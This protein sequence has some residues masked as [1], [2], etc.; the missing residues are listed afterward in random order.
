MRCDHESGA[1]CKPL[2]EAQTQDD[3]R[4]QDVGPQAGDTSYLLSLKEQELQRSAEDHAAS[5]SAVVSQS[6]IHCSASEPLSHIPEEHQEVLDQAFGA[7]QRPAPG[8]AAFERA[9]CAAKRPMH[10]ATCESRAL[11]QRV[12]WEEASETR[13]TSWGDFRRLP[14]RFWALLHGRSAWRTAG[15]DRDQDPEEE[16]E[17]TSEA[18]HEDLEDEE[19]RLQTEAFERAGLEEVEAEAMRRSGGKRQYQA[20]GDDAVLGRLAEGGKRPCLRD[21]TGLAAQLGGC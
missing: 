8:A 19:F 3:L 4:D 12:A 21:N 9:P 15:R 14:T 7:A 10:D 13:H 11:R 17:G 6:S 1:V 18:A 5:G 16:E 2:D 20:L